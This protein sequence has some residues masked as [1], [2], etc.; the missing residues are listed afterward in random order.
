MN[1]VLG[2]AHKTVQLV[3]YDA[4]WP[5]LFE[6]EAAL[7]RK[8]LGP[9]VLGIVHIG[10]TAV[11]GL[12]A[13]PIVDVMVGVADLRVP[14]LL[15]S[16]L[17]DLGYVHRPRDTV[18][19]RL[20]FAKDSSGLRTHNLSVCEFR[21]PF[22]DSHVKFRD[23]LRSDNNTAHAYAQLKRVLAERFPHDRVAYTDAK[24]QFIAAA[25]GENEA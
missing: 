11:P 2:L 20:F 5:V 13:K 23:R 3:P 17:E 15:F 7:I 6:R 24:D 14:L 19:D 25:I 1:S 9:H 21:S 4:R 16:Q 22:W 10:S 8:Q 18:P 12:D